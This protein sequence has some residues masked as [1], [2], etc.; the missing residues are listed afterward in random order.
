MG[1]ADSSGERVGHGLS[2]GSYNSSRSEEAKRAAVG[3]AIDQHSLRWL[4]GKMRMGAKGPGGGK[5]KGESGRQRQPMY[6]AV[7]LKK[8]VGAVPRQEKLT[9]TE[10]PEKEWE[11]GEDVEAKA[12][13]AIK[14]LLETHRGTFA[15]NLQELGQYKGGELEI[16]L[17]TEILTY[18]RRRRRNAE[19]ATICKENIKELLALGIIR[20]SESS[21]AAATVVTTRKDLIGAVLSWRMCGDY[22]DINKF[23][24][25]DRYPMPTAEDIFDLLEGAVIFTTIDL[26]QGFNQIA[27]REEDKRKTAFHKVDGLYEYNKMPF[28]MRN[29]SAVFQRVMDQVLHGIPA[30]ACYIDDVLVFSKTDTQQAEDLRWMLEAI[31][32]TRLT[33]HP[34]KCKI[35]RR[36]VGYLGF[37]LKGGRLGIQEAKVKVLDKLAP[38]KDKSGLRA[39]LGFLNYYRKFVPNFSRRANFLNQLLREGKRWEW[40]KEEE[41]AKQDLL[42]AVRTGTLLQIPRADAPFTL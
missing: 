23:T 3:R 8:K 37:E 2:C 22:R 6:A 32:A 14:Q 4:L 33:C 15:Y 17:T 11:I 41:A 27:I 5:A 21:Y 35:V 28:G 39:L 34:E 42:E 10:G 20:P 13:E 38:L 19:D 29:A 36:T 1:R 16:K 26:R 9:I 30:A 7:E 12:T 40:G 18:Q 31:A 25:S 24:E